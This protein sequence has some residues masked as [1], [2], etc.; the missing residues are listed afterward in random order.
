MQYDQD[1]VM[2]AWTKLLMQTIL[3][4]ES[5][6]MFM[7]MPCI[8]S[9]ESVDKPLNYVILKKR[10]TILKFLYIFNLS[11]CISII[12]VSLFFSLMDEVMSIVL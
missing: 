12:H 6:F 2:H 1:N 5:M 10:G 8:I 7:S 9:R 3:Q 11:I 4:D